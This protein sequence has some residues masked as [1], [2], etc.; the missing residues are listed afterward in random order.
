L[1]IANTGPH[2][3]LNTAKKIAK[4]VAESTMHRRNIDFFLL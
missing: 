2:T 3:A 1:E 4:L